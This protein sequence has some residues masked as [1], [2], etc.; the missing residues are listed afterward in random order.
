MLAF[1]HSL[2]HELADGI[3]IQ[4]VL[5]GATATQFWGLAGLRVENLPKQIVM[6]TED[7]VDAAF[8]GLDQGEIVTIP[9]LPSEGDWH[10]FEAARGALGPNL[11]HAV[12]AERYRTGRRTAA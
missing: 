3:R 8:A 9:S 6:S 2:Q 4:A 1:T 10:T 7:L 11:S 5:P 12:T